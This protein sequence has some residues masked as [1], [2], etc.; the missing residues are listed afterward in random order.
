MRA[1]LRL[2]KPAAATG[3]VLTAQWRLVDQ[4]GLDLTVHANPMRKLVGTH[5]FRADSTEVQF[6]REASLLVRYALGWAKKYQPQRI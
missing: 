3:A 1:A 5:R 6:T 4:W 2:G